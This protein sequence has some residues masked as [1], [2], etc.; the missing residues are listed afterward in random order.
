MEAAAASCNFLIVSLNTGDTT[1]G[2]ILSMAGFSFAASSSLS[3]RWASSKDAW[4]ASDRSPF[5]GSANCSICP[6][7]SRPTISFVQTGVPQLMGT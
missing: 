3:W 5:A 1:F 6:S 4:L 7:V 2:I